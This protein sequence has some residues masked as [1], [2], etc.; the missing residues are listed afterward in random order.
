M[1]AAQFSA[2]FWAG[3]I[4][5]R[6]ADRVYDSNRFRTGASSAGSPVRDPF[7]LARPVCRTAYADSGR[8]GSGQSG[9]V[10]YTTFV[11]ERA[12][13]RALVLLSQACVGFGMFGTDFAG[14]IFNKV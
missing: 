9:R 14:C 3:A 4:G 12:A 13:K 7:P 2:G 10:Q 6:S 5:A 11:V 8:C 1:G